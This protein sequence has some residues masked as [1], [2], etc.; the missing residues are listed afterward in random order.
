MTSEEDS[1]IKTS[2]EYAQQDFIRLPGSLRKDSDIEMFHIISKDGSSAAWGKAVGI[3]DTSAKNCMAWAY[4]SCSNERLAEHN[5]KDSHVFR[6]EYAVSNSHSKFVSAFKTISTGMNNRIFD[7]WLTWDEVDD[8]NGHVEFILAIGM[9]EEGDQSLL[10]LLPPYPDESRTTKGRLVGIQ[11]FLVL[12]PQVTRMT[13][14]VQADMGGSI[15]QFL[16][17]SFVGSSLK[18]VQHAYD[19]FERRGRIVNEEMRKEFIKCIPSA[20]SLS[21]SQNV[22]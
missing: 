18:I 4:H 13:Y 15:P 5:E 17:N 22:S 16:L 8:Y 11:I 20:P 9:G 14:C 1:L 6:F 19:K 3:I 21:D 10:P 7:G 2:L 12:A